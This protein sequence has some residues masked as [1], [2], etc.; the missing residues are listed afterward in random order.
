M[1]TLGM[2]EVVGFISFKNTSLSSLS[3]TEGRGVRIKT[4]HEKWILMHLLLL[5]MCFLSELALDRLS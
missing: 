4:V 3:E 5:L 1:E 2:L